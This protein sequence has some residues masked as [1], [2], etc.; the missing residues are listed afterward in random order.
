ME[1]SI[2]WINEMNDIAKI[3]RKTFYITA[4]IAAIVAV[5][6]YIINSNA[7][8][9]LGITIGTVLAMWRFSTFLSLISGYAKH[10]STASMVSQAIIYPLWNILLLVA[11]AGIAYFLNHAAAV[12]MVIGL[13]IYGIVMPIVVLLSARK[14]VMK[15]DGNRDNG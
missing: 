5:I 4:I 14:E 12:G 10:T 15:S 13:G 8:I 9:T 11:A 6:L 1:I 2:G 3:R 7:Y